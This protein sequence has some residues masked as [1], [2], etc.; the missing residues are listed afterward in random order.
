[1]STFDSG[2]KEPVEERLTMKKRED[3]A[4]V[5]KR[6]GIDGWSEGWR[7]MQNWSLVKINTK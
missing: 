3:R 5:R 7:P 6:E 2:R 4:R 1:M